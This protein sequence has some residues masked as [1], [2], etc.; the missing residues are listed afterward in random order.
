MLLL[1]SEPNI[2]SDFAHR[3]QLDSGVK[4]VVWAFG[5]KAPIMDAARPAAAL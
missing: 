4:R 2:S 5:I 3:Q 1:S